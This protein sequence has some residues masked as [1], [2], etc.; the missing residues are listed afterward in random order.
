MS[1]SDHIE[2]LRKGLEAL[3]EGTDLSGR[4][5]DSLPRNKKEEE[6]TRESILQNFLTP[7]AQFSSKWLDQLQEYV[8]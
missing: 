8:F 7:K 1:I 6:I 2:S 5:L 4:K 3:P